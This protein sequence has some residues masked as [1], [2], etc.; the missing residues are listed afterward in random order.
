MNRHYDK[1]VLLDVLAKLRNIRRPDTIEIN[2]GADLIVGFPGE[3]DVDFA[4]T[5]ECVTK[6]SISQ[7]HAFPFSA[8]VDHYSVP[9]GIYPDQVPNHIAQSR[10]K[11]LQ[12][13]GATVFTKWA[14]KTVG[15]EVRV[16]VEKVSITPFVKGGRGDFDS[17]NLEQNPQSS[18]TLQ[19]APLQKELPKLFSGWTENYLA[20]DETNFEPYPDQEIA[21]GKVVAGRYLKIIEK[22]PSE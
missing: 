2:I 8:H 15:Q 14:E 7:L 3:T 4:D 20:C 21:R 6:Y 17:E 1:K 12:K 18:A 11:L 19:T 10:I 5:L 13:A 9:A 22:T 16:L